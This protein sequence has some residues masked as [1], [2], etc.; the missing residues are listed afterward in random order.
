MVYSERELHLDRR[1]R[2][3][4]VLHDSIVVLDVR[5]KVS[6]LSHI[7]LHRKLGRKVSH[8]TRLGYAVAN[9]CHCKYLIL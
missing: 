1:A 9:W 2:G 8:E 3:T 6:I 7:I 5:S 4:H